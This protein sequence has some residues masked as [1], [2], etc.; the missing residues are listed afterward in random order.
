MFSFVLNHHKISSSS[1]W[2]KIKRFQ[3]HVIP[4]PQIRFP[5]LPYFQHRS[6]CDYRGFSEP[7]VDS[8][9]LVSASHSWAASREENT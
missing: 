9:L 5:Q 1:F 8:P 4:E 7:G 6:A 3:K 2:S